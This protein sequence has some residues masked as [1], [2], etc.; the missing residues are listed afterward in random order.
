VIADELVVELLKFV[1]A[2]AFVLELILVFAAVFLLV[3]GAPQP[4]TKTIAAN[5]I[6]PA[7]ACGFLTVRIILPPQSMT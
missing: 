3:T 6:N 4:V 2:A 5:T 7:N 1:F